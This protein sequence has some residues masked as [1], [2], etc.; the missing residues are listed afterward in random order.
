[1]VG[2]YAGGVTYE[3]TGKGFDPEAR[4]K[5]L[6]SDRLAGDSEQLHVGF[7]VLVFE[8]RWLQMKGFLFFLF[9]SGGSNEKFSRLPACPE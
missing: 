4:S 9:L 2:M 3:V 8:T 5:L 1:M 6:V 7:L